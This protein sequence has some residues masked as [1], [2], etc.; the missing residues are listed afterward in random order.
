LPLDAPFGGCPARYDQGRIR[1]SGAF[2]GGNR[3]LEMGRQAVPVLYLVAMASVIVAMDIVFF[4]HRIWERL[5]ANIGIV[6]L[7]AAFYLRFLRH[8]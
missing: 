5:M 3:G 1:R 2:F 4:R 6:L 8:P 7:F